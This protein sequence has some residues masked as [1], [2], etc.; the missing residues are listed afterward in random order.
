[1]FNKIYVVSKLTTDVDVFLSKCERGGEDTAQEQAEHTAAD[2]ERHGQ[3]MQV[4][5]ARHR[6]ETS[7]LQE[8]RK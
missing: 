2:P 5:H 7:Q 8:G 1:M 6:G 3:Q 4:Q